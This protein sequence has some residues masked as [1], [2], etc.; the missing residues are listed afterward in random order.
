M[1]ENIDAAGFSNVS[2]DTLGV[3]PADAGRRPGDGE[4]DGDAV[5]GGGGLLTDRQL[6]PIKGDKAG[7]RRRGVW[8][9]EVIG[10]PGLDEDVPSEDESRCFIA[11]RSGVELCA[12]EY[13][14][15]DMAKGGRL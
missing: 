4:E 9:G 13:E 8:V 11:D 3:Y 7:F 1:N 5:V 15:S 6:L 14:C 12:S 10:E 2:N